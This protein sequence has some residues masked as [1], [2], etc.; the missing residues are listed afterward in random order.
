VGGREWGEGGR[1]RREGARGGEG[2]PRERDADGEGARGGREANRLLAN[3]K[4]A[5]RS[6][7]TRIHAAL[8]CVAPSRCERQA[9]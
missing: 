1:A 4:S 9:G 6:G 3:Q 5:T 7:Q 2:I 8:S